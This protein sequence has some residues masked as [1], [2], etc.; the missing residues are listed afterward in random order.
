MVPVFMGVN[1]ATNMCYLLLYK[2]MGEII[3]LF[4]LFFLVEEG[5]VLL[6]N[7]FIFTQ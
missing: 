6:T 4:V 7:M 2:E 1:G 3:V 5:Q